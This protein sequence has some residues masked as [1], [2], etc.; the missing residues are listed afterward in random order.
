M[1]KNIPKKVIDVTG[2]ELTPGE[3]SRS[4]AE[5]ISPTR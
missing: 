1:S 3:S 4:R 2:V 5:H